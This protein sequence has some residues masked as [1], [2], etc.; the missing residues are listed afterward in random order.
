MKFRVVIE[1]SVYERDAIDAEEAARE[2][3][4]MLWQDDPPGE[5]DE[6]TA[7]VAEVG[8]T[9]VESWAVAAHYSLDGYT[10]EAEDEPTADDLA[11]LGVLP[12]A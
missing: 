2:T 3:V 7:H 12:H 8:G 6:M 4:E 5:D 1:G 10:S 9:E 11:A